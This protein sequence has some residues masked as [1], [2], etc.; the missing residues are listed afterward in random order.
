MFNFGPVFEGVEN[1]PKTTY[2]TIALFML[3]V[4]ALVAKRF[5]LW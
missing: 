2:T 3:F 4:T 1:Y 5:G